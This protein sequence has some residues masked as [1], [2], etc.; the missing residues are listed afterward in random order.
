MSGMKPAH[1]QKWMKKVC[2]DAKCNW[3]HKK[4]GTVYVCLICSAKTCQDCTMAGYIDTQVPP[5]FPVAK[6]ILGKSC[7]NWDCSQDIAAPPGPI[8]PIENDEND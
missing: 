5:G 1:H 2:P 7:V 6:H 4:P 3:C 8:E